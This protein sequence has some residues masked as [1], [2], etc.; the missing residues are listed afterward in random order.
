MPL[1]TS[2]AAGLTRYQKLARSENVATL[3]S[4]GTFTPNMGM[5]HLYSTGISSRVRIR[6]RIEKVA[7]LS[8]NLWPQATFQ[9]PQAP[10]EAAGLPMAQNR[11][12]PIPT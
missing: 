8:N 4:P 12:K 11:A 7:T 5:S 1:A 10:S 3:S 2:E 9:G 6:T